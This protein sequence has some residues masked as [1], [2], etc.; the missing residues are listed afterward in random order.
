MQKKLTLIALIL[1]TL[2]GLSTPLYADPIADPNDLFNINAPLANQKVSGTINI[3]WRMYDNEQ[4]LIPYTATL[5]DPGSCK[6]TN[7]G[8]INSNN[9]ASSNASQD[10]VLSW[11]TTAT[12]SNA[13]L[14]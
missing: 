6:T 5:W 11:N 12:Q 9:N 1:L 4:A 13:N 14:A 10:N 8:N 2:I 7:F 3:S